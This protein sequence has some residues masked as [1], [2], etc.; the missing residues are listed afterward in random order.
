LFVQNEQ[1]ETGEATPLMDHKILIEKLTKT[2]LLICAVS[3]IVIVFFIFAEIVGIGYPQIVDWTQ[4]GFGMVWQPGVVTGT[5]GVIPLVFSTLYLGAGSMFFGILIGLPCAIYLAEFAHPTLRNI[6]KPSL[7]ILTGFPSI[8]IG[9]LGYALI[10]S[11]MDRYSHGATNFSMFVGWIVLAVMSLPTIASISEDAL[12]AVPNELKEASLGLGATRW[13]TVQKVLLPGAK[14]GITAAILLALGGA[15]GETMAVIAVIGNSDVQIT[16]N[17]FV[18]S[19]CLTG[20][21]V[22]QAGG[23]VQIPSPSWS[24]LFAAAFILLV[25][26]GFLNIITRKIL[27]NNSGTSK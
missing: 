6:I 16:L 2:A 11:A 9:L 18:K 12:R 1:G 27:S 15:L 5:Y 4:H 8:V 24:A 26:V 25:I 3:S 7:E 14:S 19:S 20:I 23:E 17:P 13:Q 22:Q 21:L 10:V